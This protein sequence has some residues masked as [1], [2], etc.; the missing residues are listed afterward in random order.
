MSHNKSEKSSD[1]S[2]LV[3]IFPNNQKAIINL[4][5]LKESYHNGRLKECHI[6]ANLF[7][8]NPNS[9]FKKSTDEQVTNIF[10][11]FNIKFQEWNLFISFL[12]HGFL[13]ENNWNLDYLELINELCNKFGGIPS[14]DK[15]YFACYR[16]K[17]IE[18]NNIYNPGTPEKDY[19]NKY[20]WILISI[21]ALSGFVDKHLNYSATGKSIV[22][23]SNTQIFYYKRL[24]LDKKFQLPPTI[25]NVDESWDI[26]TSCDNNNSTENEVDYMHDLYY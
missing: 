14:F 13:P 19:L 16:K 5:F 26:S 8:L 11:N 7:G 4:T 20:D 24:K 18:R 21:Y 9:K 1:T 17:E 23:E 12:T 6:F 3:G 2:F 25:A 10:T 22:T 15:Y